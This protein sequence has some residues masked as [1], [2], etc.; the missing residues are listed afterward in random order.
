MPENLR[1]MQIHWLIALSTSTMLHET[2]IAALDLNTASC[3]LLDVLN[4]SASMTH[5]LCSQVESRKGLKVD[6]NTLFRPFAL[7]CR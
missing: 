3:F 4:V 7:I 5:D 2:R 1:Y 6:G